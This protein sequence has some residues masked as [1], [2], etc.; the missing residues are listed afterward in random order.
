MKKFLLI[1]IAFCVSFLVIGCG[2]KDE[3]TDP[4]KATD[5]S[6]EAPTDGGRIG[7]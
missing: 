1:S 2:S 7:R 4:A 5:K 6:A 3:A